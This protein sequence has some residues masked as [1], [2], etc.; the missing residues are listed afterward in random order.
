LL[1]LRLLYD[2]GEGKDVEKMGWKKITS[3]SIPGQVMGDLWWT[4][5]HWGRFPLS[6]LV[7]P[8]NSH[9]IKCSILIYHL[10]LLQ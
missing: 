9:S 2:S 8:T 10:G 4:K 1:I 5:W 3:C 7:S 6:I